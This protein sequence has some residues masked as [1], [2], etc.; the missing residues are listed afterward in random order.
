MLSSA[1]FSSLHLLALAIGLPGIFLRGR[2]LGAVQAGPAA[3]PQVF[4][5]DNAWGIAALLW[6]VTGLARAFGP[7][8]KGSA[9][10]L[11]SGAF[12]L[13][14]AL[15]L[16]I[17]LLEIAPMVTLIRWRIRQAKGQPIDLKPARV[18]QSISRVQLA[19]LLAMPF[20]ASAMARG[21][22]FALG[23]G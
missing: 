4:A 17:L 13:K 22:G 6:G 10:Y 20:V 9:Y 19:L 11:H 21:L 2:A 23:P 14:M 5:A 3:L 1:I 7:F 16:A 18:F 8:E 15:F 12:W